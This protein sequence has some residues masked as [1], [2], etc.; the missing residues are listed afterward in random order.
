M[1]RSTIFLCY[2]AVFIYSSFLIYLIPNFITDDFIIFDHISHNT[3][4]FLAQDLT[5]PFRLYFRPL[6]Y[7]SFFIDFKLI[8]ANSILM[9]VESL[10]IFMI[11]ISLI[12]KLMLRISNYLKLNITLTQVLL[13]LTIFIL[14]PDSAY[15]IIWISNRTELLM[16]LFYCL[17]FIYLLKFLTSEKKSIFYL[18]LLW[19]FFYFSIAAKQTGLHLP[20]LILLIIILFK[21]KIDSKRK[22]NILLLSS[23]INI[24]FII[25][26]LL[27]NFESFNQ[28]M[29][30]VKSTWQYVADKPF[31]IIGSFIFILIPSHAEPIYVFF[32]HNKIYAI[33]AVLIFILLVILLA[34]KYKINLINIFI[35]S[36]FIIIIFFPRFFA[37]GSGRVNSLQFLWLIIILSVVIHYFK[38]EKLKFGIIFFLLCFNLFGTFE[39]I[40]K[41]QFYNMNRA[42]QL[43]ELG[44]SNGYKE[45]LPIIISNMGRS[46]KS[47]YSFSLTKKFSKE[48][49]EES[50]FDYFE[51][52]T[53]SNPK[54]LNY[55][56]SLIK[57][58]R[59]GDQILIKTTNEYAY[60]LPNPSHS[61]DLII[62]EKKFD[63]SKRGY[64]E[65][66]FKAID[67]VRLQNHEAIYFDGLEW[68]I[69]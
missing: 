8:S 35:T 14:H 63:K 33:V 3:E 13:L 66:L 21:E 69:F 60:I 42:E 54:G 19:I 30:Y 12:F 50:F 5:A 48:Q 65:V 32:L 59:L 47:E 16:L 56:R 49:Q 23:I 37:P 58:K 7:F 44:N 46:L 27:Q 18:L 67:G 17:S 61:K 31:A 57:C 6:S 41:Y 38:N 64:K 62:F 68:K 39:L 34:R 10:I 20:L 51:Y 11:L 9:K 25:P 4:S 24:V 40:N 45:N 22:I 29:S 1:K 15:M 28:N 26:L 43:I 55:S 2:T 36:T 53:F 52:S